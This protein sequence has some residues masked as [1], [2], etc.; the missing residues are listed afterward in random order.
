MAVAQLQE[1]I[2]TGHVVQIQRT[3]VIGKFWS[4]EQA[5]V[6]TEQWN[7]RDVPHIHFM[8]LTPPSW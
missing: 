2:L 7:E 6:V 8:I 3:G 1:V 5:A 4:N